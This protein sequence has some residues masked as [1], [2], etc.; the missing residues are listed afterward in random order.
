MSDPV[1]VLQRQNSDRHFEV[2]CGIIAFGEIEIFNILVNNI[3]MRLEAKNAI[4]L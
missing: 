4:L 2:E 3:K 1:I